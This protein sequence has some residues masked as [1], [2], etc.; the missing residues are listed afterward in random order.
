LT[1]PARRDIAL[2]GELTLSG[3]ILAVSGIREKILAAQRAGVKT[4]VFP[5][6]NEVDINSLETEVKEGVEI[7][8]A[9]EIRSLVDL[10]LV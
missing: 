8:L 10:V 6:R 9:E 4:V 3:R 7:V 2:T 5:K 1:A